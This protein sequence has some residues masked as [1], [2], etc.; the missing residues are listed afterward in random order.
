[1]WP[2]SFLVEDKVIDL[3]KLPWH[4]CKLHRFDGRKVHAAC[5]MA[6]NF[7]Y[8]EAEDY[9]PI[10][11]QCPDLP[12]RWQYRHATL[13]ELELILRMCRQVEAFIKEHGG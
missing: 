3:S 11:N 2:G 5:A 1:M 6:G 9:I 8:I 10:A 12:G 4:E 13:D 7:A